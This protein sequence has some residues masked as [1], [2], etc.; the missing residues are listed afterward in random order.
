MNEKERGILILHAP[1][2]IDKSK[3]LQY[4]GERSFHD[5]LETRP[6]I[7]LDRPSVDEAIALG[8][9]V[10]P[11]GKNELKQPVAF[12]GTRVITLSNQ[13]LYSHITVI[14]KACK[15]V[16]ML[17]KD[18]AFEGCRIPEVFRNDKGIYKQHK[19]QRKHK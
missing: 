15:T 4:T 8:L 14:N 7:R 10:E 3:N 13:L 17:L 6:V 9:T 12:S 16:S 2:D 1:T 11:T 5:L 19:R 18:K